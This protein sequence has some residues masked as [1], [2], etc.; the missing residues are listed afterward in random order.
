MKI[1]RILGILLSMVLAFLPSCFK[2][3]T[4]PPEPAIEYIDFKLID[5]TDILE[6]PVLYGELHFSFVDGDGD[7]GFYQPEGVDDEDI[8][9]TVFITPFI[10]TN[11]VF[12]QDT[13]IV[14]LNFRIPYFETGGNNKTLKGEIIVRDINHYPPFNGDTLKYQFYIV[15]RAGNMS[16]IEETDVMIIE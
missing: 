8:A 6:N 4:Y 7:L 5:S 15:D 16:N 2:L 12:V 9:K 1:F 10:K 11:G 3:E 13:P 14:P